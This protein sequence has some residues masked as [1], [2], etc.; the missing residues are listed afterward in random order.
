VQQAASVSPYI[1]RNPI[2]IEHLKKTTQWVALTRATAFVVVHDGVIEPWMS[3]FAGRVWRCEFRREGAHILAAVQEL[4]R[5][6]LALPERRVAAGVALRERGTIPVNFT[7]GGLIDPVKEVTATE[8]QATEQSQ[9]GLSSWLQSAAWHRDSS[10]WRD[11]WVT[12]EDLPPEVVEAV[13]EYRR[14]V[15]IM[16]PTW[17][18]VPLR[19]AL[20][21]SRPDV[22][23]LSSLELEQN[24]HHVEWPFPH[25]NTC[26][27]GSGSWR[28]WPGSKQWWILRKFFP[29][30]QTWGMRLVSDE[31]YWSTTMAFYNLTGE[32]WQT[33]ADLTHVDWSRGHGDGHPGDY[34]LV[35]L[36]HQSEGLRKVCL[37]L[38]CPCTLCLL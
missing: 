10:A 25:C 6:G 14:A 38:R 11:A 8:A 36:L 23:G 16:L 29:R 19:S 32:D 27:Q 30:P 33:G 17:A 20:S 9:G 7:M 28:M 22:V 15:G 31:F 26:S 34:G 2:R 13:R 3:S 12:R 37:P 5:A 18:T 21:S 35:T 4:N 24:M 1:F